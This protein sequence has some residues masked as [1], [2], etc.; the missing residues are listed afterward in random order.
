M[1]RHNIQHLSHQNPFCSTLYCERLALLWGIN[2]HECGFK[3]MA[4]CIRAASKVFTFLTVFVLSLYVTLNMFL[5]LVLKLLTEE[6]KSLWN[7]SRVM[8]AC[9]QGD[10]DVRFTL[11]DSAQLGALNATFPNGTRVGPMTENTRCFSISV[12][13]NYYFLLLNLCHFLI[14][15]IQ[16]YL[17]EVP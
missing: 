7:R 9:V 5:S 4:W 17:N 16:I 14:F 3:F 2:I 8:F 13:Q 15:W 12:I 6:L 10:R 11:A 1:I